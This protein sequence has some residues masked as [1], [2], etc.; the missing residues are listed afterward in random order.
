MYFWFSSFLVRWKKSFRRH[1][2]IFIGAILGF[3]YL[4][5]KF[6][7]SLESSLTSKP[8]VTPAI[9]L[10]YNY[11]EKVETYFIS[12]FSIFS[13][14]IFP[15]YHAFIYIFLALGFLY[16]LLRLLRRESKESEKILIIWSIAS[17]LLGSAISIFS[18][19][20][21]Q[22]VLETYK[23]SLFIFPYILLAFVIS[24]I[25]KLISSFRVINE[26][27]LLIAFSVI[28]IIV[29]ILFSSSIYKTYAYFAPMLS[30]VKDDDVQMFE[31]ID[32][33]INDES[34]IITNGFFASSILVGPSDS[35]GWLTIF[36]NNK[37]ST[38]FWK[39][40]HVSTITNLENYIR[41]QQDLND[42]EAIN[43]FLANGFEYYF[44][45]ALP[46]RDV[47][48][49]PI[50]L[51]KNGWELIHTEGR[52]FLFKIPKCEELN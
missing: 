24:F 28:Y 27:I 18:I 29:T 49:D 10:P 39:F 13:S 9:L 36:T 33:N 43:Y 14:N 47:L 3:I 22:I 25:L 51:E 52:T 20:E 40:S 19:R 11:Y 30:V 45:G 38:P 1:L 42:C 48:G 8:Q 46:I 41:L 31:W 5:S 35:G 50:V 17:L 34:S 23:L 12:L 21:V 16:I 26:K 32:Q 2:L 4:F 37:T 15:N 44:Q 7:I 6:F